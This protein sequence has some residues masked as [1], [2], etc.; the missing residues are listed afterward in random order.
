MT[1]NSP[2]TAADTEKS[3]KNFVIVIPFSVFPGS[4]TQML[5]SVAAGLNQWEKS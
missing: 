2:A 5:L 3:F 1:A 4:Q